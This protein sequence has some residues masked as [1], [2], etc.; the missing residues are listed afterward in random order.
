MAGFLSR[1]E[2]RVKRHIN[3]C[4]LKLFNLAATKTKLYPPHK[5]QVYKAFIAPLYIEALDEA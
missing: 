3:P 1:L 4:Q 2:N 5:M